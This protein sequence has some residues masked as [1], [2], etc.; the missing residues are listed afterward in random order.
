[1]QNGNA[2][3]EAPDPLLRPG[4]R[5]MTLTFAFAMGETVTAKT[6]LPPHLPDGPPS[7]CTVVGRRLTE[8][9]HGYRLTYLIVGPTTP[10]S[11]ALEVDEAELAA[12]PTAEEAAEIEKAA[13]RRRA[14]LVKAAGPHISDAVNPFAEMLRAARPGGN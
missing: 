7:R 8:F 12:Y 14:E 11:E 13:V 3:N 5:V 4:E 1:M 9:N 6:N 10:M 2:V